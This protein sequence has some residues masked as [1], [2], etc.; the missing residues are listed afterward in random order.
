VKRSQ[1]PRWQQKVLNEVEKDC[2]SI[3]EVDEGIE[4]IHKPE[5]TGISLLELHIKLTGAG[6][7]L[8]DLQK[9]YLI[10]TEHVVNQHLKN[11]KLIFGTS[12]SGIREHM[13][14]LIDAGVS[15]ERI[16]RETGAS[17]ATI[18]RYTKKNSQSMDKAT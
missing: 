17:R 10:P 9:R 16:H 8:K 1:L 4:I 7:I 11:L 14:F 2:E 13:R 6:A 3:R 18:Y 5:L 15:V 12:Q